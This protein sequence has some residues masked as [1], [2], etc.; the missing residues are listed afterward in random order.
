MNIVDWLILAVLTL[1]LAFFLMAGAVIRSIYANF[2]AFISPAGENQPSA[3]AQTVSAG[4]DMLARSIIALAKATFMGK[5]SGQVRGEQ[6]V[7]SDIV[8]DVATQANP[9]L[10]GLLTQFPALSKTLKRNPALM[11]FALSKLAGMGGNGH[12]TASGESPK[13]NL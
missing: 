6:A 13:F 7:M 8:Q 3:L 4:A 2:R 10:G 5:Q 9:L 11:D 12:K 1:Q